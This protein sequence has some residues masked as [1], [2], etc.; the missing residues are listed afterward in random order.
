MTS[1]DP[2]EIGFAICFIVLPL[3]G[4]VD[5]ARIPAQAWLKAGRSKR[6]WMLIQI[7]TLYIGSVMYLAGVRREVLFFNVPADP[8]WEEEV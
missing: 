4:V 6:F 2:I 8:D 5:A 7:L 1:L 3:W